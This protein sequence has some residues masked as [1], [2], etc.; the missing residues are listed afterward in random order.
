[1]LQPAQVLQS[2]FQ[3]KASNQ[4]SHFKLIFME[5][6]V[7]VKMGEMLYVIHNVSPYTFNI[8][9]MTLRGYSTTFLKFFCK[10]YFYSK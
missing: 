8:V 10:T 4:N 2:E 6:E 5:V 7:M 3:C 1:M 9:T